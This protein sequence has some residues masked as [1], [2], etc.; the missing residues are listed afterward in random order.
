MA[1]P[2]QDGQ[3]PGNLYPSITLSVNRGGDRGFL[4]VSQAV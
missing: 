1:H 2:K 3:R 4:A